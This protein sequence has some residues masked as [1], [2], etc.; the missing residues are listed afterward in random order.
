M[1]RPLI[2]CAVIV[3]LLLVPARVSACS[4]SLPSREI[5]RAPLIVL[6]TVAATWGDAS[7]TP[8]VVL[9]IEQVLKGSVAEGPH[10]LVGLRGGVCGD[11]VVAPAGTRMVIALGI[12]YPDFKPPDAPIINPYWAR[13]PT[14]EMYWT[15]DLPGGEQPTSVEDVVDALEPFLPAR[16]DPAPTGAVSDPFAAAQ[17]A[18]WLRSVDPIASLGFAIL[19]AGVVAA[20]L[21]NRRR[22]G[23]SPPP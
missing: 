19:V 7:T 23:A 17:I 4:G 8:V 9:D 10:P 12:P 14:G 18:K 2:A 6:G 5:A 22:S 21:M 20:I 11:F 1:P 15:A 3:S 16:P 13:L